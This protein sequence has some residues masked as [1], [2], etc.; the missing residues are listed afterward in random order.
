MGGAVLSPTALGLLNGCRAR[1]G[2]D[3]EP[4]FFAHAQARLVTTLAELILPADEQAP[5]AAELGVPAFIE[6]MLF[7]VH[8][9]ESRKRVLKGLEAFDA[10]AGGQTENQFLDLDPEAQRLFAEEQNRRMVEWKDG[11]LPDEL[12]FFRTMKELTLA[13]YFTTEV[14]ATQV[15]RY[16][17][18]PGSYDG[19]VPLEEIG[20]TWAV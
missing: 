9:Q 8:G 1:P 3:W 18:V 6:E 20:K 13:G 12:R 15:L 11:G 16:E 19:C 17:A 4:E 10:G 5:G 7:H 2:V 14:G